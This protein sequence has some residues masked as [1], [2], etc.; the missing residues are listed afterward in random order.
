MAIKRGIFQAS[1]AA[2]AFAGCESTSSPKAPPVMAAM[3]KAGG[4]QQVD[5]ATLNSGRSAFVNRCGG[6]HAL[7]G[8]NEHTR[9]QWPGIVAEMATRSGL[10]PEQRSAVLDYILAAHG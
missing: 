10:K 6:C 4:G 5:L 3:T 2:L 8:V 1:I 7:P 9:A